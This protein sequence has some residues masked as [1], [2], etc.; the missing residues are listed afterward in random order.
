M[1]FWS[2]RKLMIEA[3]ANQLANANIREFTVN[4]TCE[5]KNDKRKR[6]DVLIL[7]YIV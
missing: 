6:L 5:V 2:E 3:K 1:F 4:G 7:L